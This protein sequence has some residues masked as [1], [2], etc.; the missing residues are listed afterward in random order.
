MNVIGTMIIA[1]F[2]ALAGSPGSSAVAMAGV[3]EGRGETTESA[4]ARLAPNPSAMSLRRLEAQQPMRVS[5]PPTVASPKPVVPLCADWPAPAA[6][7]VA[8]QLSPRSP[9]TV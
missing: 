3:D 4:A 8:S 1:L 9:P 6:N 5:L 7:E 2:L